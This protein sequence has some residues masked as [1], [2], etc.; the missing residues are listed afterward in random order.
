MNLVVNARDAMLEGGQL[1]IET[2][3][4]V[5][6]ETYC[7]RHAQAAAGPHVLLAV[8]DSGSG[9]TEEARAHLFEPFFTTKPQGMGTG[10]G[11]ATVYG[12]VSQN[13]GSVEVDSEPGR[14]STFKIY[15]PRVTEPADALST[16]VAP[17]PAELPSGRETI[18]LVE[19]DPRVRRF[20]A[21]LLDLLGY[22]VLATTSA[23]EAL[24]LFRAPAA[25]TID[26]LFT[27]VVLPGMSGRELAE[28]LKAEHG[29]TRVLFTSGYTD[30]VIIRHGVLARGIAFLSKPYTRERLAQKVRE[31]LD[32]PGIA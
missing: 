32:T 10:L 21:Q 6:D 31:V 18:L 24:A 5:L 26:L 2:A 12:A 15:F 1:L 13:G 20:A 29:V 16:P 7:Q 19:D 14:G 28:T 11:L 4:V 23:A 30:D 27:D 22:Q 8:T 9:L 25:G 3:D 17:A